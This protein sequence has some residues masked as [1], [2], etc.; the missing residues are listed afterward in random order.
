MR[1]F[2]RDAEHLIRVVLLL[3]LGVIA[4]FLIR[5]AVVPRDFGKYGHFRAGSMDDV[6]ARPIKFAGREACEACHSDQAEVKS[7]GKHVH[8]GCEACHGP[9]ARHA[10]DPT[11]VV[12]QLPDTA[13]LC[14]RCHEANSAKPRGFP[15]VVS[16]EHS[17]GLACNT[18]HKPHD[19]KIAGGE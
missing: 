14:V 2:L 1:D 18:C 4:F 10:E 7:K 6:R 12:P 16:A 11:N 19:P 15:Q 5:H 9:L 17:G 3:A 13:V 8:V